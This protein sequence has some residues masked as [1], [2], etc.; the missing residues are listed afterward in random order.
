[1]AGYLWQAHADGPSHR[2]EWAT[3]DGSSGTVNAER[4]DRIPLN[5]GRSPLTNADLSS[6]R[7]CSST[8]GF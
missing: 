7:S 8:T 6:I 5:Q 2:C 1:M 3:S 4:R